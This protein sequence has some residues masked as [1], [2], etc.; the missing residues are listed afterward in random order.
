M[1]DPYDVSLGHFKLC[2]DVQY[3]SFEVDAVYKLPCGIGHKHMFLHFLFFPFQSLG[4]KKKRMGVYKCVC[5]YTNIYALN[6]RRYIRLLMKEDMATHKRMN[7]SLHPNEID[8]LDE[9]AL[10]MNEDKSGAIMRLIL[11]CDLDKLKQK[12]KKKVK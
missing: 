6:I 1:Q 4:E 12:Y 10:I 9:I 5:F 11:D 3:S 8:K 2:G 7:I